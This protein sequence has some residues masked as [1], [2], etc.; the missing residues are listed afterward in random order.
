MK[1]TIY[2]VVGHTGKLGS[3]LVQMPNFVPIDCD[4]TNVASIKR[5]FRD[6]VSVVINCADSSVDE[7]ESDPNF[8]HRINILGAKNLMDVYGSRVLCPSSDHVFPSWWVFPPTESS[9]PFPV[10]VYGM[11]KAVVENLAINTYGAK[12]IRLSRTIHPTD[13]DISEYL[14]SLKLGNPTEIPSFFYRNYLT[15]AQAVEG[16]AYFVRNWNSVP[17]LVN[18]GLDRSISFALLMEKLA[19]R[20]GLDPL[21]VIRRKKYDKDYAAPRPTKSG[22]SVVLAKKLGF[23]IYN[24]EQVVNGFWE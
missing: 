23:P 2:G 20:E 21:L 5:A 1:S 10:N 7:C 24:L 19:E 4:I 6:D 15:R 17:N 16:V 12:V 14:H 8:A 9:K 22:F 3:L 13:W 11:A 18:Y